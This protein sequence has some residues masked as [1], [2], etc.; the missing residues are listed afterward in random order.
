M[1]LSA[2]DA[3]EYVKNAYENKRLSHAFGVFSEKVNFAE[4]FASKIIG[5]VSPEEEDSSMSLFGDAML[6]PDVVEDKP[7]QDWQSETVRIL[8]PES[9]SR[10]IKV[11]QLRELEKS[12]QVSVAEGNWKVGVI[13]D[14]E[15]M[16]LEAQNA[17]LKTLEEPPQRTLL[18]LISSKPQALLPTVHSRMTKIQ[19]NTPADQRG[20]LTESEAKLEKHLEAFLNSHHTMAD[21]LSLRGGFS[22]ILVEQKAT[23]TKSYEAVLKEEVEQYKNCLLYTSDAAD[24]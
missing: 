14:A 6:E 15:R 20:Q 18:I 19:L 11:E 12:F 8:S 2:E 5:L 13:R 3:F 1:S 17:F 4:A 21:A 9:K 10:R 23:I 16:N 24:D 22:Q 7:L